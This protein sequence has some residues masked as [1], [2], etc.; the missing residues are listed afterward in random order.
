VQSQQ[1]I[2]A[3]YVANVGEVPN[4]PKVTNRDV[5]FQTSLHIGN[6]KR[7]RCQ[8]VYWRLS[9]PGVVEGTDDDDIRRMGQVVLDAQEVDGGLTRPVRVIGAQ[10][11]ILSYR[12]LSW[13]GVAITNT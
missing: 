1:P 8:D 12:Y 2:S 10:W 6:L 7:K 13:H 4:N 3:H 9:W 11:A 5:I